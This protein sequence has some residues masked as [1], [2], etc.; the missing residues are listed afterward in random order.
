MLR[1]VYVVLEEGVLEEG[2]NLMLEAKVV[3]RTEVPEIYIHPGGR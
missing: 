1:W 3:L 2:A